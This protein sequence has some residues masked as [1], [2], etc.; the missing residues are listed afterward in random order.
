[1]AAVDV[2]H[3][4]GDEPGFFG[5]YEH[6]AVGHLLGGEAEATQRGPRRQARL[7]LGRLG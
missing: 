7:V 6:D 3:V 5:A 4:A 2:E 1:V